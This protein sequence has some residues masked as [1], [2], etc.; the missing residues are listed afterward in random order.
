MAGEDNNHTSNDASKN[1]ET[2]TSLEE[3]KRKKE[4]RLLSRRRRRNDDDVNNEWD[5]LHPQNKDDD[6]D[7]DD[8][9]ADKSMNNE[10]EENDDDDDF[11][12]LSKRKKMEQEAILGK[13]AHRRRLLSKGE[14][15][16]DDNNNNNNNNNHHQ[17][18][19]NNTNNSTKEDDDVDDQ[20]NTARVQ[21]LLESANALHGTMTEEERQQQQ[22]QEEEARILKEASKVQTNA[23][24]AA[25]ELAKGVQY[26]KSVPST[27]TAPRY[28]LQQGSH[29]WDQIRKEWHTEVEGVH[30]P[31]PC[32]RFVDMKFPSPILNVLQKKGIKKPTP[33]QMQ[34]LPVALAGRD[35]IGIAFT[36]SG[37][38]LTF[39]LPLVMA[40]LEEELRMPIVPGEGP[41]GIILAPSRELVRQTYDVVCEFCHEISQTPGYPTL[42]TQLVIGGES[43]RD[44]ISTLQTD[45]IHCVVATPGRLRDILK[46]KAMRLDNCRYICLDEA[47][48]LLDLGFDE[49]LGEIM[50]SFD[51]QR[52]TLLFSATFPKK[53]QD[54]ARETLVRPIIV[55]VGR[56]GA[57]NLDV[58]QE[59]EYV[60]DDVKIPYLLQC[61]QKTAPP[62]IIF[63]ER[64][65][66]VDDI[67]EYLL[68]KGVEAASIHGG[69]EQEE[70]NEA[71]QSFK[72]GDKDVL[73]ATDVAA[74]GLDF[75]QSIQH[76]INFDMPSEIEN[77]VHRIGRTGR[78][79]KTGVATTFINKSCDETTL[80]DLKHLLKEAR[81]RIPPVLMMLDDP[82]EKHGGV[83]CSYCGGLGHT[84]VDCPKIDKNARQVA[85]G[86]KDALATGGGYG[87]D[88]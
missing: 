47:D 48:R 55:N 62:V 60:K 46:R 33:I 22:R 8:D 51:H 4:A 10:E 24:Q 67:H 36:G 76:V 15:G 34:G 27:W 5:L 57:A 3:W 52:Q 82:R 78:C 81:Q 14:G 49:E 59:V 65:G 39:S 12:P 64:K 13:L 6:D 63:C 11:V 28:I 38:T 53:F 85:S 42:R 32:K 61:L 74:K 20:P 79:G 16:D 80:L 77:Y 83:G 23:L 25:S 43:V 68:L 88:W 19:N 56:A 70:R 71:I 18:D 72:H 44:Q 29:V 75:P 69:K 54:F 1:D 21:S 50:N 73:V 66:D 31:P 7:D 30:I 17:D 37:K 84:I 26:T 87:G 40:A 2:E 86:K 41:I 9:D 35:M 58:I 45:G